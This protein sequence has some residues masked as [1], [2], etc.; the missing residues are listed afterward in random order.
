MLR[1]EL[2][3]AETAVQLGIAAPEHVEIGAVQDDDPHAR[4]PTR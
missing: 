3:E 2:G 1:L 4:D